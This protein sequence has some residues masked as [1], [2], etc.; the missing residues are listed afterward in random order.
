MADK[1]DYYEV[2]GV[3]RGADDDTIKKAFRRRARELHPDVNPDPAA[4]SQFKEAAEAY[5]VLSNTES[6]ELYDTYGHD[7][8][9]GRSGASD[10][11]DFGSFQDLFDA[12]FG[13]DIFGRG[14]QRAAHGQ[15]AA[16]Q[17]E[18]SFVES[19]MGAERT[20]EFEAV[21]GCDACEATGNAPGSTLGRC[22]TCQ[23]QG[24]VRQVSRGPFGQFLRTTVCN[25]C[26]GRGQVPS[27]PCPTCHGLG[28]RTEPRTLNITIPGGIAAGQQVRLVGRGHAGEK[29]ASPGDLYVAVEVTPDPRFRRDGLDVVSRFPIAVT[30]AMVGGTVT[31]PTVDGDAHVEIRPGTQSGDQVI[32][33]GKG[34]PALQGR[35]KGDQRVL[36]DVK[37][38]KIT[39]GE[40]KKAVQALTEHIDERS[41]SQ[42]DEGFLGRLK[43]AFR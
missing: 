1:R 39:S 41:F 24:Q 10:F 9:R 34:F 2:L 17:V 35:G 14:G 13:G 3:D 4:E 21:T 7:G 40:G 43:N 37:V 38:P 22:A 31:V 16:V 32:L 33:R 15:D 36:F 19:A 29:G 11:A 28:R 12:F 20:V 26:H 25:D 8:L 27:T 23:G 6:R 30:E 5:E 18:I 42:D